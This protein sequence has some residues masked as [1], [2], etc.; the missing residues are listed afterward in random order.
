MDKTERRFDLDWLRVMVILTVFIYHSTR[1]FNLG[2]WHVKNAATYV[3]VEIFEQA[4]ATWMMPLALVV[5]G[6]GSFYALGKG[7]PGQFVKD[8]ALRLLVPLV[9]GI[10][11]HSALQVYWERVTHDQFRGTFWQFYPHYFEGLYPFDG[12]NFGWM[13]IHLWYLEMLFIFSLIFLP[14]LLWLRRGAGQRALAHLGNVLAF[15]GAAILLAVPI[16]M[17]L[18]LVD[19][20]SLL[21]NEGFGSW[22]VLSHAW[23]FLS[24]FLL[25]SHEGVR[26]SVQRLRWG[27][28]TGAVALTLGQI[29][30]WA[31]RGGAFDLNH[32]DALAYLWMLAM[33]G[34]ASKHLNFSTPFLARANE[35]VLPFYILHQPVLLGVGVVVLRWNI[36]DPAK[37]LFVTAVSFVVVIALYELLVRRFDALRVL[38]GMKPL[39][40]P[41]AMPAGETALASR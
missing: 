31:V 24:G 22:S 25:V 18:N 14:L 16:V 26:P 27:W 15:P 33:L 10:F 21:G 1:F 8:K 12:G 23:F 30:L 20:G 36:P 11:T 13:S 17:V 38:F 9:V 4:L 19:S 32:T 34:F 5:S 41:S 2:D 3:G 7:R 29:V 28:L 35:A 37:Y 39:S 40:R 6:A